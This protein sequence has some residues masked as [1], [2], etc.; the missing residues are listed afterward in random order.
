[1]S[2][3]TGDSVWYIST[4]TENFKKVPGPQF[5]RVIAA[6]PCFLYVQS[7]EPIT[8]RDINLFIDVKTA[9]RTREDAK[10]SIAATRDDHEVVV[11]LPVYPRSI[12]R[13]DQVTF[14]RDGNEQ[15]GV[16]VAINLSKQILSY[17]VQLPGVTEVVFVTPNEVR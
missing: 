5:A 10:K 13:G 8:L 16:V 6:G 9:F 4:I 12:E 17:T 15:T 14:C 7:S 11:A 3:N 2:F 1:M